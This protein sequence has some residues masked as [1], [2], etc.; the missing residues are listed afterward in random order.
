MISDFEGAA[1]GY[2]NEIEFLSELVDGR[3]SVDGLSNIDVSLGDTFTVTC[4]PEHRL[5]TIK[6]IL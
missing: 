2:A 1:Q 4:K 6:F 3:I 5:K